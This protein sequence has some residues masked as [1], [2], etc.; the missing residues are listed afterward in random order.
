MN[1]FLNSQ[2][3]RN[4]NQKGM[5]L[6]SILAMG[7]VMTLFASALLGTVMPAFQ[8][9]NSLRHHQ[10]LRSM[11]EVA[12]DYTV[13]Q[14]NTNP[15]L[16]NVVVPSS[17][18]TIPNANVTVAISSPGNPPNTSSLFDPLLQAN[19]WRMAT[20]TAKIG[21]GPSTPS[22]TKQLRCL[23]QPIVNAPSNFPY[24]LFGIASIIYAG[25]SGIN[26]YNKVKN[27]LNDHRMG[28][29][30]G[31]LGKISQVWSSSSG[32]TRSIA[33]GGSHYEY[34]N[35]QS[36]YNQ[37]FAIAGINYNAKPASSAPWMQMMGNSYSN[38][39]NTAYQPASNVTYDS[40]ANVFGMWNGIDGGI[41]D[42]RKGINMPVGSPP[43]WSGGNTAWNVQPTGSAN[44]TYDQPMIPPAPDAPSGTQSLGNI[45]LSN[46][47]KLI[48]DS[49]A[50]VP[51][52]PIG[53]LSGSGKSVRIPPGDYRINSLSLSGG[54]SVEIATAT[55]TSSSTLPTKFYLEGNNTTAVSISNDSSVN[56]T[57]ITPNTGMNTQG[58]NGVKNGNKSGAQ[59][60]QIAI[61][62]PTN[63]SLTNNIVETAG[64]AKQLQILSNANTNIVLQG[65]ERMLVYAPYADVTVGSLLSNGT[66]GSPI[67]IS[68]N[69][70]YYGAIGGQNIYVQS[71]YTSGGGAFVHY[72]WNLRPN[73]MEYI[74][75]WAKTS[76]FG[77]GGIA[78]YRAVTWQEA[79]EPDTGNGTSWTYK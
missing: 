12:M 1:K 19:A 72:D 9:A 41:P 22:N 15:A 69:A 6:A 76:P 2:V 8:K 66:S 24:G 61:N 5:S 56:M 30:G 37:Q 42:G 43:S 79:V 11:A 54:S 14:L 70:N 40:D 53:S 16:M 34:P 27:G 49:T 28:A 13:Q 77:V 57:G 68:K 18:L 17:L 39:V 20:V 25:Q 45:S 60:D 51:T 36:Y 47:A 3:L 78:G 38:G 31:T 75:P 50:P 71:G 4:R 35:P 26:T 52:G 48:I 29:D 74:D 73:G 32:L 10:T 59:S 65:N 23:L 55:Q 7:V 67:A 21:N 64:S 63:G 62:D 58:K 44:V 33:Q 46:G